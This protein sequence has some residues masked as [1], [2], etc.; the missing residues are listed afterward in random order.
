MRVH[1]LQR[2]TRKQGKH[3]CRHGQ[4]ARN[5]RAFAGAVPD[6]PPPLSPTEVHL[7]FVAVTLLVCS[8]RAR[9]MSRATEKQGKLAS[10]EK[11]RATPKRIL[12]EPLYV[13]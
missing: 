8:M 12:S 7:L 10:P 6:A 9:S 13:S 5:V 3:Q 2:A 1:N 11:Q 4:H